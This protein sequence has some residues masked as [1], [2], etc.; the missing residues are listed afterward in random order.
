M[1][2]LEGVSYNHWWA[3]Y[4]DLNRR[5]TNGQLQSPHWNDRENGLMQKELCQH[6]HGII[7]PASLHLHH[8]PAVL[9]GF[10][11]SST[12]FHK[13]TTVSFCANLFR[14]RCWDECSRRLCFCSTILV[15]WH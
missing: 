2:T 7:F 1:P 14:D 11:V 12:I 13:Q 10:N 9:A 8:C 5:S 6:R 4:F 15:S 3:E